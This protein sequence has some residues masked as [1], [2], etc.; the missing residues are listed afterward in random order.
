MLDR[1]KPVHA[2]H[3]LVRIGTPGRVLPH[4]G[5]GMAVGHCRVRRLGV[6]AVDT[7]DDMTVLVALRRLGERPPHRLGRGRRSQVDARALGTERRGGLTER[8]AHRER[9]HQRWLADG[10]RAIHRTL[11]VGSLEQRHVEFGW[12]LGE[13]GQLVSARRLGRQPAAVRPVALVPPQVFE[14]EPPGALDE[15]ALDLADVDQRRQ[16]VAHIVHDVDAPECG[17]RR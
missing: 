5:L 8:L 3:T 17:R 15:A 11:L 16:A 14:S 7:V 13:A 1:R 2:R 4:L 9:Q 6:S 12:Q 10:L